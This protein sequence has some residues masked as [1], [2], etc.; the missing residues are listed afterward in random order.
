MGGWEAWRLKVQG[1]RLKAQ[2]TTDNTQK[3]GEDGRLGSK[4][5]WRLKVQWTTD[6]TQQTTT[7]NNQHTADRAQRIYDDP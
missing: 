1:S 6:N 3:H 7:T 5:T 4:E 2:R